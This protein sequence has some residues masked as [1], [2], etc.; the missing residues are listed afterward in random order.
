M[1]KPS[2][3]LLD[4]LTGSILC[5]VI[6]LL[7]TGVGVYFITNNLSSSGVT[8]GKYGSAYG[9]GTINGKGMI[10]CAVIFFGFGY[11]LTDRKKRKK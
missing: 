11:I 5:F 8:M 10:F 4:Y 2:K 9:R 1:A 3:N 6:G 7:L